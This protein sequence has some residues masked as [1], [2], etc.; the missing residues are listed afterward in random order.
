[1]TKRFQFLTRQKVYIDSQN[2]DIDEPPKRLNLFD[3]TAI[4]LFKLLT[5]L[6]T[7]SAKFFFY[8]I[9]FNS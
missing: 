5:F 4:G 2:N 1:M 3:I 6:L 8:P 7:Y 9:K